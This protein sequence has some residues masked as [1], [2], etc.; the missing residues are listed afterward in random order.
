MT[1][2]HQLTH[3]DLE[4]MTPEQINTARRGGRL[5]SILGGDVTVGDAI[6]RATA[7]QRLTLEDCDRLTDAGHT[8]LVMDAHRAGRVDMI[9]NQPTN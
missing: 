1:D 6:A 8:R 3:D 9:P 2:T 7:G 4:G 5:A